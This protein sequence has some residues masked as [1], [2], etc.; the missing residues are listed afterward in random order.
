MQGASLEKYVWSTMGEI[1]GERN[2]RNMWGATQEKYVELHVH[3]RNV[4]SNTREIFGELH[5][6]NMWELHRRNVCVEQYG[7]NIS[8]ETPNK[9]VRSYIRE[10]FAQHHGQ[11]ISG[12][13]QDTYMW[14][15]REKFM[16]S[17]FREMCEEL[18]MGRNRSQC[19]TFP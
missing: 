5:R 17:Y 15:I 11:N 19:S 9:Y 6:R 13:T 12:A 10:K 1:C 18:Y 7:R 3:R 8:G 2:Q 14:S 16:W 4:N